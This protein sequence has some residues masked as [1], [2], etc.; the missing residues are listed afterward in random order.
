MRP[1]INDVVGTREREWVMPI[2]DVWPRREEAF[3][4]CGRPHHGGI[5]ANFTA[6]STL[7]LPSLCA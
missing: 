1:S 5:Q 7:Q 2:A 4:V 3:I 6:V